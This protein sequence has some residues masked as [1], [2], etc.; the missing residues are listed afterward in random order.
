MSSGVSL[1]LL[2]NPLEEQTY[3]CHAMLQYFLRPIDCNVTVHSAHD[4]IHVFLLTIRFFHT[5]FKQNDLQN[6]TKYDSPLL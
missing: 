5:F 4:A 3:G 1:F 6:M 2:D